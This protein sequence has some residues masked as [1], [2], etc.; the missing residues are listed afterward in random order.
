MYLLTRCIGC[1]NT[2][3]VRVTHLFASKLFLFG[4][5]LKDSTLFVLMRD[6]FCCYIVLGESVQMS[7]LERRYRRRLTTAKYIPTITLLLNC[8]RVP[9]LSGR[10]PCRERQREPTKCTQP[11]PCRI[12]NHSCLA[13]VGVRTVCSCSRYLLLGHKSEN[14]AYYTM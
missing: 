5:I 3:G 10:Q 14:K 1:S 6:R 7:L 4:G 8:C 9:F 11:C 13:K 2:E 12:M